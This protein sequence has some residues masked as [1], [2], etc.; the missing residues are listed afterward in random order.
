MPVSPSKNLLRIFRKPEELLLKT[1]LKM[2]RK[3]GY[4]L[5]LSQSCYSKTYKAQSLEVLSC[6]FQV[7]LTFNLYCTTRL[8]FRSTRPFCAFPSNMD[9]YNFHFLKFIIGFLRKLCSTSFFLDRHFLFLFISVGRKHADI[10]PDANILPE[11]PLEKKTVPADLFLNKYR[12]L[13]EL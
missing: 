1:L 10:F 13:T 7:K 11:R 6:F 5:N 12:R 3:S 9:K 8:N 2:T 4:F